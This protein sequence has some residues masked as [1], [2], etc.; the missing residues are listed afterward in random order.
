MIPYFL[1]LTCKHRFTTTQFSFFDFFYDT[2]K[3]LF[4]GCLHLTY[5][6]TFRYRVY[7]AKKAIRASKKQ[8]NTSSKLDSLKQNKAIYI[9]Y[10]FYYLNI[11]I[12]RMDHICIIRIR[13]RA[14]SN[15]MLSITVTARTGSERI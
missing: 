14:A 3:A 5:I 13:E 7:F 9:S 10:V 4:W 1:L 15:K 2:L 8:I 6:L 11:C 12:Y